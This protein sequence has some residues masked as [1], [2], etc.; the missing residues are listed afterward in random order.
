MAASRRLGAAS[1]GREISLL[2]PGFMI[3]YLCVLC[4]A[5]ATAVH[6]FRRR[7][8]NMKSVTTT[9]Q[10]YLSKSRMGSFLRAGWALLLTGLVLVMSLMVGGQYADF[11]PFGGGPVSY[12]SFTKTMLLAWVVLGV[13]IGFHKLFERQLLGFFLQYSSLQEAQWVLVEEISDSPELCPILT[14]PNRMRYFDYRLDRFLENSACFVPFKE[15]EPI[16]SQIC[17]KTEK[18]ANDVLQL[19][20][21][22]IIRFEVP[23]FLVCLRIEFSSFFYLYQFLS[24]WLP[25]YWD[26]V[27]LALMQAILILVAGVIKVLAE[28]KRRISLRDL[29]NRASRV[30]VCRQ[31]DDTANWRQISSRNLIPGDLVLLPSIGNT[32]LTFDG[33]LV[34]GSALTDE[35]LLTGESCPVQK[36]TC[37]E[38]KFHVLAG[39]TLLHA[40][41]GQGSWDGVPN[42]PEIGAIAI[43]TKTGSNTLRASL[44]RSLLFGEGI[45]TD[46]SV[47]GISLTF[48]AFLTILVVGIKYGGDVGALLAALTM[49]TI[50]V[51]P[52]LPVSVMGGQL[53]SAKRLAGELQGWE[54]FK[55]KYRSSYGSDLESGKSSDMRIF[56]RDIE[57][58]T[59]AGSVDMVCLDKT[60]TITQAGLSFIRMETESD[61]SLLSASLALCHSVSVLPNGQ[62]VGN[63]VELRMIEES[64]RQG[65][66]FS[67][68]HTPKC[69]NGKVWTILKTWPFSHESATMSVHVK[70]DAGNS[71]LFC[72]G[73][74]EAISSRC[75]SVTNSVPERVEFLSLQGFYVIAVGFA[76]VKHSVSDIPG[77]LNFL[78]LLLF[79]NNSKS[80]SKDAIKSLQDANLPCVMVTGDHVLTGISVAREVGIING[81]VYL[82]DGEDDIRKLNNADGKTLTLSTHSSSDPES[83]EPEIYGKRSEENFEDCCLAV[84]GQGLSRFL[85]RHGNLLN[86]VRVFGRVTPA[87][88][89]EIVAA[90]QASGRKVLFC[91]DGG[92]DSGALSSAEAGLAL[93]G[94]PEASVAAPF[95][96]DSESL[97]SLVFLLREARSSTS[98]SLNGFGFLVTA[99]ALNT[100]GQ[101]LML[102]GAGA[103]FSS[104]EFMHVDMVGIPVVLWALCF[105]RPKN[106]LSKI[107]P[108]SR[109]HSAEV[110][111][112]IFWVCGFHFL[113]ILLMWYLMCL[114]SW[115]VPF[116]S[117][118][119]LADWADRGNN[120][121]EALVFIWLSWSFVSS[122]LCFGLGGAHREGF[123]K[124]MRFMLIGSI[125][126]I[127]VIF[128]LFSYSCR[129]SCAY[130]INC[131][132]HIWEGLTDSWINYLLFPYDRI[133]GEWEGVITNTE[134]PLYWKFVVFVLLLLMTVVSMFGAKYL[135]K[136]NLTYNK[137]FSI[138]G[139]KKS[140]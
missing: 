93:A 131:Q 25:L 114:Q 121:E 72:K 126:L 79:R 80:D 136:S 118:A 60:G 57:R 11:W 129:F 71:I 29:A 135:Q 133:G 86:R 85:D 76:K 103:F 58:L 62:R 137:L 100:L 73:S 75:V 107:I 35:S 50:L 117:S 24:V 1:E 102:M 120:Y 101:G 92:N 96:T 15:S 67:N 8:S 89:V 48:G 13:V 49:A 98:T 91:G 59:L 51:N 9:R 74:F 113:F 81:D 69:E 21:E 61:Q 44:L 140:R 106:T 111:I 119:S 18:T 139:F 104:L 33:F 132:K 65:W 116:E 90:L 109:L 32:L 66:N 47:V 84:T 55:S 122:A 42:C 19:I 70:N 34:S 97:F 17:P 54:W 105:A 7:L 2:G 28:R 4:L 63:Q 38:K 20:G 22:N 30:L 6:G 37:K 16:S 14:L 56:C 31:K 108:D 134:F 23:S 123:W 40:T 52:L 125:L 112:M 95:S 41:Q 46:W 110:V 94:R 27:T 39:T 53:T 130:K 115:Y 3:V 77:N 10:T 127:F 45:K 88:K 5:I 124:N 83:I 87:Q 78:G 12:D 26:Y 43:V 82:F 128:L 138:F 36:F 99:G 68:F 64:E